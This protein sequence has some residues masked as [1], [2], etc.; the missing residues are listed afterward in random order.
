VG[1]LLYVGTLLLV[2][3]LSKYVLDGIVARRTL[4]SL[5][6][7]LLGL[8]AVGVLRALAG[9]LR[10]WQATKFMALVG[11][12]LRDRLYRHCQRLSFADHARLGPGELM[13]RVA[14]DVTLLETMT[15]MLPFIAQSMVL[16]LMGAIVLFALQPALAAGVVAAVAITAAVALRLARGL[17][18][19][20]RGVQDRLGDFGQFAEQQVNGVRV[21]KGHGFEL[22]SLARGRVLADQVR[23]LGVGLARQRARFISAFTLAPSTALLIVIG[24]GVWLGA[25]GNM[26]A[27]DIFA[28][29][30][31]LGMLVAPVLV[32]AQVMAMWPMAVGGAGRVAEVLSADPDVA[33]PVHPQPLPQGPGAIH[34]ENV[35][36]GYHPSRPV[37]QGLDL[38][39][40]GGTSVAL[41]GVSGAGKTTLA[42]L[43]PRFYDAWGGQVLLDGARV[44]ELPLADLRRAVSIVFED[45]VIFTDTIRRN[46]T[47]ARP[48]AT[49]AEVAD[50]A[51][52]AHAS[53]FIEALPDGYDTVVGEQGASLSGGQRQRLA[54]ARAIL[55]RPRVLIL[56]DAMSAVDP[57]TDE[58]IR[59]GLRQVL[60]GCTALIIAH[61]VETLEL[62]DRVVLLDEGRVVA[63]G[64]HEA[65]LRV[66]AYRAALALDEEIVVR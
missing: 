33:N 4:R 10:K 39:V 26:T 59:H 8:V 29:M 60:H 36:F 14:G 16:G 40:E 9:A 48:D 6:P 58:A 61:R 1:A 43:V 49:D 35:W 46:L 50:A 30:Q 66:P 17:Y 52:R 25:R 57:A 65:L 54:I 22:A 51:R 21:I 18:P 47:M 7:E 5:M 45:T 38:V 64:S 24:P 2:P 28:F 12:D 63:D 27:G 55:A 42:Y 56:D 13:S 37:L 11:V 20:S 19:L 31:Y 44:D 53:G 32:G 3:L 15:G 23:D 41:V 34:F 62:A